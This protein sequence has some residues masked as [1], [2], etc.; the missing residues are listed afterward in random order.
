MPLQNYRIGLNRKI[1]K[2]FENPSDANGR[3][4]PETAPVENHLFQ[5]L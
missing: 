4:V 1:P 5:K 2:A 3:T